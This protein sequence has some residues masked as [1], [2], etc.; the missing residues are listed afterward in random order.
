M[1]TVVITGS[2]RGIGHGLANAFLDRNCSVTINGRTQQA[3]EQAICQLSQKHT[4]DRIFGYP[5]DVSDAQQV[6]D[7]WDIAHDH[8]GHIDIWI[9]NAGITCD[10]S[11]I[12]DID[13][14]DA[15]MVMDINVTGTIFGASVAVRGMLAQG[16]GAIY[17][18]E[19]LGSDGRKQ[20]GLALYGTSKYAIKYFTD[21]LAAEL[22][23]TPLIV[24]ALQPGMVITDLVLGPYKDRP[25]E[26][27][28]VKRILN[29]IADTVENVTPWLADKIL[30]NQK[31]GVRI[32]YTSTLKLLVRFLSAP[33]S[34]R[35]LFADLEL[36]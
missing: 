30:T 9:N 25:Q 10:P 15:Q 17:N 28:R 19:G 22:T 12:Q 4:Q 23:N 36:E 20:A 24:G 11:P 3:V 31:N 32:K 26:L 7:L 2:T 35:D 14:R 13:P 27:E 16:Y 6:Q 33:F 34:K 1:K 18:L 21:A 29:I 5:C 8:F